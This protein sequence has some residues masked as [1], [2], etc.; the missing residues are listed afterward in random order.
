MDHS[1][2]IERETTQNGGGGSLCRVLFTWTERLAELDEEEEGGP[3]VP[4]VQDDEVK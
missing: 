1:G 4:V 2:R 3:V